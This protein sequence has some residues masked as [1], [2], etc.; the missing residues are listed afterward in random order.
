MTI[1]HFNL[2]DNELVAKVCKTAFPEYVGRKFQVRWSVKNMNLASYWESGCVTRFAVVDLSTLN[3]ERIPHAHPF[4][5]K[6]LYEK[7]KSV[8][9]PEG[10]VVVAWH[11]YHGGAYLEIN[12][13]ADAPLLAAGNAVSEDIIHLLLA[14][15]S[16]KSSYGGVSDL[17]KRALVKT[18]KWTGTKVDELRIVAIEQGYLAKNKSLTNAGRNLI[19]NHPKRFMNWWT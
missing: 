12:T 10:F 7:Y 9:L 2:S 5:N 3:V 14:T 13:P 8:D 6:D 17:R 19:V 4:F 15:Q 16:L 11:I 1:Q 18:L